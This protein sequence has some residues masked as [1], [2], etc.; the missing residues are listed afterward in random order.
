MSPGVKELPCISTKQCGYFDSI[1]V[2]RLCLNHLCRHVTYSLAT[3]TEWM[4]C[5]LHGISRT[6]V[7]V[8]IV[9]VFQN[10]FTNLYRGSVV[11]IAI[12]YGLD[13]PGIES[14]WGEIFSAP[15]QTGPGAHPASCTMGTVSFPGAYFH[16]IHAFGNGRRSYAREPIA[17]SAEWKC[18]KKCRRPMQREF[19]VTYFA[20]NNN[21]RYL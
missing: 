8:T 10:L 12:G 9:S 15:E 19:Q 3:S 18:S 20:N 14:R 11:G 5:V 4:S 6:V 17:K 21:W 2:S 1:C 16:F 7:L 13:G